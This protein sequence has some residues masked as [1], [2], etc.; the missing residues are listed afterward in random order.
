MGSNKAKG[1]L[2]DAGLV[3]L[4]VAALT[5]CC[6]SVTSA[7]PSSP[8][9]FPLPTSTSH[10]FLPTF[11]L[12]A[13][14]SRYV[15]DEQ[16]AGQVAE[17]VSLSSL[18]AALRG[19]G[20][21]WTLAKGAAEANQRRLIAATFALDVAGRVYTTQARDVA[22]I[23]EWACEQIRRRLPSEAERQWHIAALA[24]LEGTGNVQAVDAHLAHAAARLR[25]EPMWERARVWLADARTLNVHPRQ[26]LGAAKVAFPEELAARYRALT[27]TPAL[28]SD[29]LVRI[30]FLHYLA[31]DDTRAR[32][33]LLQAQLADGADARS[34]Y[35]AQLFIGWMFERAT[36]H[37]EAMG[38]FR[39]ALVA[40]PAGRTAAAWLA[41]RYQIAGR[42]ADAESVAE[43]SLDPTLTTAD[44]WRT[45]Y[46]GE[47]WRFP[48]LIDGLRK[49][50][51]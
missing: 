18:Y 47:I 16:E 10:L 17:S 4:L 26:P 1:K 44:P 19:D 50:G 9:P 49:A 28:A 37:D 25:D 31:G 33:T 42:H 12:Q 11:N 6:V 23:V 5:A 51:R 8:S 24:L 2:K 43:R 20:I 7:F 3:R 27:D 46:A 41:A 22:P 32:A 14:L 29:A 45:F 38:A 21:N 36:K 40:E 48:A 39:A 35:L 34:R 30:G 15:S 13:S